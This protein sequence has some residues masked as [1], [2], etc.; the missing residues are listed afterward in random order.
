MADNLGGSIQV[1]AIY[2]GYASPFPTS[3][4]Q[5]QLAPDCRI[6]INS[7]NGVDVLHTIN[8]PDLPGVD[9]EIAQHSVQL[10]TAHFFSMP[11][12]PNYRLGEGAVCDSTFVVSDQNTFLANR[13]LD[14]FPNPVNDVLNIKSERLAGQSVRLTLTDNLG[15][16]VQQKV[17]SNYSGA[18]ALSTT[19]LE[20][21]IYFLRVEG[22]D[23]AWGVEKVV[24]VR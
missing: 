10:H 11:N 20:N 8:Y 1:V 17:I 21:G 6:Y 23:G 19:S 9:C 18:T 5:A 13:D 14:I 16:V 24:V 15:A 7:T 12:F 2:D 22:G 4:Y 3:F